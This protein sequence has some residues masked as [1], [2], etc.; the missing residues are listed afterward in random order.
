[1]AEQEISSVELDEFVTKLDAFAQGLSPAQS[2]L[3][4]QIVTRAA[5]AEEDVDGHSMVLEPI[6]ANPALPL[7]HAYAMV[8][9]QDVAPHLHALVLHMSG[10]AHFGTHPL[11]HL[12]VR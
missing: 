4:A 8:A 6:L 12:P 7:A 11:P 9:W 3:L 1:M 10:G 2:A 5:T